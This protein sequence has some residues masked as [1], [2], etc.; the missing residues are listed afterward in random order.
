MKIEK[1]YTKYVITNGDF[2]LKVK[3]G[4]KITIQNKGKLDRWFRHEIP[5]FSAAENTF[6]FKQSTPETIDNFAKCLKA[7]VKLCKENS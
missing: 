4:D 6:I 3:V 7:A 1:H 5:D 2:Q